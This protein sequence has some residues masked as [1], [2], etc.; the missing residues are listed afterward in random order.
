[1]ILI[2]CANPAIDR[3]V[4]VESLSVG[5]V[6]R[7]QLVSAVAG[8]KGYNVARALGT[9]GIRATVVAPLGGHVGAWL[10]QLAES[11]GIS[12]C[13]IPIAGDTRVCT[14]LTDGRGTD[15]VVNERGPQLTASDWGAVLDA[16]DDAASSTDIL[17][18]SGS[19]PRI[20]AT[21]PMG[22][23]IAATTAPC[24]VDT[25][26]DS[27]RRAAELGPAGIKVNADEAEGLTVPP[28]TTI[29]V[30]EGA[31]GA[32]TRGPRGSYRAAPPRIALRSAVGAGDAFFA[33]WLA[34]MG[35]DV[36]SALR[37]ACAAGADN[38]GRVGGGVVDSYCVRELVPR[39]VVTRT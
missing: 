39:I 18:V 3:T 12:T 29:V 19:L 10:H 9:L 20:A 22:D 31:Q 2:I 27:L 28:A 34:G 26:G 11:E 1:M 24:W 35:D 16:I 6:A 14:V 7:G 25:S 30:T 33:G 17:V 8:G 32:W 15:T 37:M 21:D 13:P 5:D 38:A 36:A 4:L 23:L